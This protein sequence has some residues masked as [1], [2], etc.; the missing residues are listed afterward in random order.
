MKIN[1]EAIAFLGFLAGVL[2]T[3]AVLSISGVPL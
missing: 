3:L 2:W 1:P